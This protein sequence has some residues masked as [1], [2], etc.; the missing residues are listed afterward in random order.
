MT[1]LFILNL[2]FKIKNFI[3]PFRFNN[4]QCKTRNNVK[5]VKFYHCKEIST[6]LR[7]RRGFW[8]YNEN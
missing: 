7:L 8:D 3:L 6:M 4:P 1:S 2:T 5:G